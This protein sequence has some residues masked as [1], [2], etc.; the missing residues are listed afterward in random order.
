MPCYLLVENLEVGDSELIRINA[1]ANCLADCGLSDLGFCGNKFTW[2]N[3]RY[4]SSYTS[5]RLDRACGD[6]KWIRRFPNTI[7]R[8]L[9]NST[10]EH[11]PILIDTRTNRRTFVRQFKYEICGIKIL[12]SRSF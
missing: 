11:K 7:V 9:T 12:T 1:F 10:F 5:E 3:G 2:S 4:T 6:L 8:H